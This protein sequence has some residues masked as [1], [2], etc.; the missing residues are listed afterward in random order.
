MLLSK[1]DLESAAD[2]D[3]TISDVSTVAASAKPSA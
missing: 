3:L 1:E 2:L